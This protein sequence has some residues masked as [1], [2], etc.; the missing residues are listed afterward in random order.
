MY[1]CN[2]VPKRLIINA[3]TNGAITV[4]EVK[5]KTYATVGVGCCTQQ[6]EKLI[7]LFKEDLINPPTNN[8]Q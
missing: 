4:A 7:R 1:V 2:E 6:V 5:A 3:I 8:N